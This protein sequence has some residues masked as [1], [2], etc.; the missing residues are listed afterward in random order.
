MKEM[1][2][3]DHSNYDS[4]TCCL[5]SHGS[6]GIIQGTDGK[7][8]K[9]NEIATH[10]NGKQCESLAGKPKMFFIQACRGTSFDRGMS[11]SRGTGDSNIEVDQQ[12]KKYWDR[13]NS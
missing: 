13:Q 4:F 11:T 1:K 7:N 6:E 2:K 12:C 9:I 5:M 10:L 8:V 3:R